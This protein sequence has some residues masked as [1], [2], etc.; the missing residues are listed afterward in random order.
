MQKSEGR[1]RKRSW[2]I[3]KYDY[4]FFFWGGGEGFKKNTKTLLQSPVSERDP[5]KYEQKYHPLDCSH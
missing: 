4:S 3:L 5:P 2:Q 1:G